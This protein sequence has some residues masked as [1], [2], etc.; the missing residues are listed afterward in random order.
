MRACLRVYART[1][2]RRHSETACMIYDTANK[3]KGTLSP[4]SCGRDWL[5]RR[6]PLLTPGCTTRATVSSCCLRTQKCRISQAY[7]RTGWST[8]KKI[9]FQRVTVQEKAYLFTTRL[10][11]LLH[12]EPQGLVKLFYIV[13]RY[14]HL[15][16]I[17]REVGR[18][19]R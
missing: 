17:L 2:P 13:N 9:A 4:L 16:T 15:K 11:L 5:T 8:D 19:E 14:G 12:V 18:E 6:Q 10:C 7:I 3:Y 1:L